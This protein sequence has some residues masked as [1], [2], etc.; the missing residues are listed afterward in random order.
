MARS[1]G[2]LLTTFEISSDEEGD[3]VSKVADSAPNTAT[4]RKQQAAARKTAP[5]PNK[6][7]T[8]AV[9]QP[10]AA[11]AALSSG[12]E[13]RTHPKKRRSRFGEIDKADEWLKEKKAATAA[14]AKAA[15]GSSVD[16]DEPFTQMTDGFGVSDFITVQSNLPAP[17]QNIDF[18]I[19]RF[20]KT[21]FKKMRE[22]EPVRGNG[23]YVDV[24]LT[25]NENE[26]LQKFASVKLIPKFHKIMSRTVPTI[27][28]GWNPGVY[29]VR[30]VVMLRTGFVDTKEQN[31]TALEL[32]W[33]AVM[34]LEQ[35]GKKFMLFY[36]RKIK[37]KEFDNLESVPTPPPAVLQVIPRSQKG[38]AFVAKKGNQVMLTM[39]P[40]SYAN[41]PTPKIQFSIRNYYWDAE[42]KWA[43]SRQGINIQHKAFY[44]LV[45][46]F[47]PVVEVDLIGGLERFRVTLDHREE[48]LD[49]ELKLL[50]NEQKKGLVYS[51][52]VEFEEDDHSQPIIDDVESE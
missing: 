25:D 44:N 49:E 47:I 41:S 14:A 29:P 37:G 32:S 1:S 17:Q 2:K 21:I 20:Q 52:T 19:A 23:F 5:L 50:T 7:K 42:G 6:K 48:D 43:P 4:K 3:G 28:S 18:M 31:S 8:T 33:P 36:D 15:E 26:N 9:V 40:R 30:T 34:T 38:P 12:D 51:E 39:E 13:D 45:H 35:E 22:V 11:A 24:P 46:A 10:A 16:D 27:E